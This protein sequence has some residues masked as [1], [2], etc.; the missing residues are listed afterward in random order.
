MATMTWRYYGQGMHYLGY[1][2]MLSS[3]N[4]C[5][6]RTCDDNKIQPKVIHE[7]TC[8]HGCQKQYI[9]ILKSFWIIYKVPKGVYHTIERTAEHMDEMEKLTKCRWRAVRWWPMVLR[10][11]K[12]GHR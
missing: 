2:Y 4:Y 11:G 9:P 5:K 12:G 3:H 6:I 1:L 7:D 10:V 8:M